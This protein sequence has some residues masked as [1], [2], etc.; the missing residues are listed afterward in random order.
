M[1]AA[2]APH[3][4]HRP[5]TTTHRPGGVLEAHD[6]GAQQAGHIGGH[7]LLVHLQHRKREVA[8]QVWKHSTGQCK[9]AGWQ[10]CTGGQRK[11][12]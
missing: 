1:L 11:G 2:A 10:H 4:T 3:P 9:A 8:G 5:G 12:E 7:R 6:Q